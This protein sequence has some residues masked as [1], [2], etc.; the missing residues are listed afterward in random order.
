MASE[1]YK[2]FSDGHGRVKHQPEVEIEAV[3]RNG[4][5]VYTRMNVSQVRF[6]TYLLSQA[7]YEAMTLYHRENCYPTTDG[8]WVTDFEPT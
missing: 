7:E 6:A 2:A 5:I 1:V 8:R 3:N 4:R